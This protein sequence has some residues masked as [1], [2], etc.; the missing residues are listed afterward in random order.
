MNNAGVNVNWVPGITLDE[1][2]KHCILAAFKFYRGN[3]S[4]TAYSLK[5]SV[6]T[7]EHKLESYEADK[8]RQREQADAERKHADAELDRMRGPQ[9]TKQFAIGSSDQWATPDA[10]SHAIGQR[11]KDDSKA[12][13]GN[14][15]EGHQPTTGVRVE[16]TA[17]VKSEHA[18]PVS[19]RKETEKV[20]HQSNP[21]NSKRASR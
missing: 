13:G 9:L 5:I 10:T 18:M 3:K 15:K 12:N 11:T 20:L 4:Q 21:S 8:L 6:R 19:Q 1:M 17:Q 14:G 2:E 16:P 7:L